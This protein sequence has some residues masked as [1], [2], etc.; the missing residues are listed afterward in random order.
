MKA[1]T[2]LKY[3][4]FFSISSRR[5]EPLFKLLHLL[6]FQ[7]FCSVCRCVRFLC[8]R[9]AA[10][11]HIRTSSIMP[12]YRPSLAINAHVT[13]HKQP[14]PNKALINT[15]ETSASSRSSRVKIKSISCLTFK[16]LTSLPRARG[17]GS[18]ERFTIPERH[19]YLFIYLF[20]RASQMYTATWMIRRSLS[21]GAL[22]FNKM[23]KLKKKKETE[24][25]LLA[26]NN[27][28]KK[29]KW[30]KINKRNE[31]SDNQ[32]NKSLKKKILKDFLT[33]IKKYS[34]RKSDIYSVAWKKYLLKPESLSSSRTS[35]FSL[36]PRFACFLS[37]FS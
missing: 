29:K 19:P 12:N 16:P 34:R 13:S 25:G 20:I 21:S 22:S 4:R 28:K 11:L 8:W 6:F 2:D 15:A 27:A 9:T 10:L 18:A 24:T 23:D 7:G 17:G 37:F 32:F 1:L 5:L 35:V 3:S 30:N 31:N 14:F 36:M 26:I 33:L